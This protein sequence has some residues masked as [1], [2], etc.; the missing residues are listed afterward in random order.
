MEDGRPV[1]FGKVA[2]EEVA[3]LFEGLSQRPEVQSF[4]LLHL[5]NQTS[6]LVLLVAPSV[7]FH[8]K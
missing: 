8:F 7:S 6:P 5:G 2:Y 4:G 1:N 3:R